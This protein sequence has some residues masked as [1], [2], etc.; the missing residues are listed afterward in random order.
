MKYPLY[1]IPRVLEGRVLR[2]S[3]PALLIDPVRVWRRARRLRREFARAS[4]EAQLAIVEHGVEGAVEQKIVT[5]TELAGML[6]NPDTLLRLHERISCAPT[7][8]EPWAALLRDQVGSGPVLSTEERVKK[9]VEKATADGKSL[10]ESVVDVI[11][12]EP[13]ERAEVASAPPQPRRLPRLNLSLAA[14]ILLTILSVS[15]IGASGKLYAD[16]QRA[17][18]T[19]VQQQAELT[20]LKLAVRATPR[21]IDDWYYQ[22]VLGK[23]HY[24]VSSRVAGTEQIE[25]ILQIDPN[26]QPPFFAGLKFDSGEGSGPELVYRAG[27]TPFVPVLSH[28]YALPSGQRRRVTMTLYLQATGDTVKRLSQY[29]VG[30]ELKEE[31]PLELTPQGASVIRDHDQRVIAGFQRPEKNGGVVDPFAIEFTLQGPSRPLRRGAEE[32]VYLLARPLD[33]Y[34]PWQ[35]RYYVLPFRQ[36]VDDLG[37]GSR[38]FIFYVPVRTTLGLDSI[39]EGEPR[40]TRFEILIVQL[41]FLLQDWTVPATVLDLSDRGPDSPVLDS[42]V[43][44]LRPG[45]DL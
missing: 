36:P 1:Y 25:V 15:L 35:D 22:E 19:M 33:G 43:V 11:P 10:A 41:P 9:V 17:R 45:D 34:K 40:P 44:T 3:V 13:S 23:S 21:N 20:A 31:I 24:R 38:P 4:E 14:S 30:Y 5:R 37:P 2:E 32:I 18:R 12:F 16:R 7:K 42:R 28:I 26:V 39:P 6:N 29:D 8:A 27:H